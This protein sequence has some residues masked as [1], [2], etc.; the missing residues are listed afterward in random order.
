MSG[1]RGKLTEALEALQVPVTA[2]EK[3]SE[4][5]IED[6]R[7][8]SDKEIDKLMREYASFTDELRRVTRGGAIRNSLRAKQPMSKD[9]RFEAGAKNV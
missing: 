5:Q 2:R 3:E 9:K 6:K 1:R 4:E 8:L 7:P